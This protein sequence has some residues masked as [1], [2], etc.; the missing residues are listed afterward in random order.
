M[1][2]TARQLIKLLLFRHWNSHSK[3]PYTARQLIESRIREIKDRINPEL[4]E[5][6][7]LEAALGIIKKSKEWVPG[8]KKA[9][10][11]S[12]GRKR[13]KGSRFPKKLSMLCSEFIPAMNGVPFC[14]HDFQVWVKQA[15][16]FNL[17]RS[18]ASAELSRMR[19]QDNKIK[20]IRTGWYDK[21]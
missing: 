16:G 20:R 6:A 11:I 21:V 3:M 10:R 18:S 8:T 15:Y 14:A 2:Y 19:L 7:E 9:P 13:T 4:S 5:L 12:T 1:P 17:K